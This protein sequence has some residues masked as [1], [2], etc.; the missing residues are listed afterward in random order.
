MK[1]NYSKYT[2]KIKFWKSV[3]E[4]VKNFSGTSPP[5][6]FVGSSFYPK[7]FVGVLSPTEKKDSTSILD[8]PENWYK[9]RS[10]ISD[11][12]N[13]RSQ[14][15]LSRFKTESVINNP[16]NMEQVVQEIASAK[17]S[18]DIEVNL[19]NNPKF[20]F[21][22]EKNIINS[23]IGSP[24][25][26]LNIKITS[27][28]TIEK[29]VNYVIDDFDLKANDAIMNLYNK[30]IEISRLQKIF[31][32]GLLGNK[33]Q[34]KFVP[35]RW[36]I[37]AVDDIIGKSLMKNIHYYPVIDKPTLFHN[38]YLGNHYEILFIPNKYRFELIESWNEGIDNSNFSLSS[39]YED[40]YGRKNYANQ[41]HGAFYA[42]RLAIMEYFMKTKKQASVLIIREILPTYDVPLGIWQMRETVRG[43]FENKPETFATVTQALLRLSSRLNL[44]SKWMGKSELLKNLTEQRTIKNFISF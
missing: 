42:G 9:N 24:A 36:G 43:A 8:S 1:I 4:N 35:T 17:K 23:P 3:I 31:S 44:G 13:Y 12:L 32:S 21:N 5:S 7:V 14:M 41:T 34:R 26:V 6:V 16:G 18:T 27:N 25:Q 10:S 2:N 22:I 38:E 29:K 33:N 39:D 11:I 37:T 15:I 40:N 20:S 30:G 28:P 19:K